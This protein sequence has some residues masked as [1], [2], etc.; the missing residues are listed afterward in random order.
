MDKLYGSLANTLSLLH[1]MNG[2]CTH[3]L[4]V[5]ALRRHREREKR[6]RVLKSVARVLESLVEIQVPCLFP[7]IRPLEESDVP[8]L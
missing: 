8:W 1:P 6:E 7:F 2:P 4:H 3:L 5:A